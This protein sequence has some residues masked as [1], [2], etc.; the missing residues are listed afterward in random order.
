MKPYYKALAN[1][2]G[3]SSCTPTIVKN[4]EKYAELI[5][6]ECISACATD[7]LGKTASAEELIKEHFGK[8][9]ED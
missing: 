7:A 1:K 2:A 4:L 9:N 5:I 8:Q 3:F 6:Q